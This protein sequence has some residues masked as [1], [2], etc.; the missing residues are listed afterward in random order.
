MAGT[1]GERTNYLLEQVG[2][3]NLVGGVEVNQRYAKYQHE[4]LDLKHKPGRIARFLVTPLYERH[5]K[6]LQRLA[7][8][9]LDGDLAGAMAENMED[10]SDQVELVAPIDWN[11]LPRSGHPTVESDGAVVY[12]RPPKVAR[13]TDEQLAQKKKLGPSQGAW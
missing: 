8:N 9:V 2:E 1:F 6:Y 4:R 5:D 10:L 7:D 3:G 13:L 11:D 12:D